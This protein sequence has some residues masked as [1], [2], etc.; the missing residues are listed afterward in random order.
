MA[1]SNAD[2]SYETWIWN[3]PNG[4][5]LYPI[6][7]DPPQVNAI[8]VFGPDSIHPHEGFGWWKTKPKN[9]WDKLCSER[10]EIVNAAYLVIRESRLK[11]DVACKYANDIHKYSCFKICR[12][13]LEL[14]EA[15]DYWKGLGGNPVGVSDS[16]IFLLEDAVVTTY[17]PDYGDIPEMWRKG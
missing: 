11:L 2:R 17:T 10:E 3:G 7:R 8:C 5:E 13:F 15:F 9:T 14:C 4:V 1:E 12:T 16:D 6:F